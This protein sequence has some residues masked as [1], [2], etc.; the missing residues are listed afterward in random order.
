MQRILHTMLRVGDMARSVDFYTRVL[1]MKVLRTLDQPAE[2]YSLTFLGYAEE[3]ESA[4][5]ELTF[6]YGVS[7]YEL[8]EGYGHLA[9]GVSDC[10]AACE[11]IRARG[12]EITLSPRPLAGSDEIIAFVRDPDGYAIELLQRPVQ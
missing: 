3:S 2:N 9:I 6:N 8:G 10:E 11:V 7:T 4:V 5:L 12:G 1:G